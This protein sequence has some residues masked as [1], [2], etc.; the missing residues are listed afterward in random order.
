WGGQG[1]I[2]D[3][4]KELLG[5]SDAGIALYRRMLMEEMDR[6]AAGEDPLGTVRDPAKNTY[7]KL[8]IERNKS[9]GENLDYV[10][11]ILNAYAPQYPPMTAQLKELSTNHGCRTSV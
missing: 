11:S 3:R 7:I 6:V 4:S 8:P 10:L 5:A 2:A 9:A 1:V